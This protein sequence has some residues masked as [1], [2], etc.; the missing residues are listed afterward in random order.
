MEFLRGNRQ[1]FNTQ[2][3]RLRQ[4]NIP[5]FRW[6]KRAELMTAGA[7]RL[8][9]TRIPHPYGIA[10]RLLRHHYLIIDAVS[11]PRFAG[12]NAAPDQGQLASFA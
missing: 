9:A 5:A 7:V 1:G 3:S 10:P 8:K 11:I 12:D 4:D 2:T 6:L